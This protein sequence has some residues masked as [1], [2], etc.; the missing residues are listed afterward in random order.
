[1]LPALH[2]GEQ[3]NWAS[4]LTAQPEVLA[5]QAGLADARAALRSLIQS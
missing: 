5:L 4:P 3:S 1:M 2:D